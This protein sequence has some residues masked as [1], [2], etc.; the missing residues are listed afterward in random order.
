M[1][2]KLTSLLGI[3]TI[4]SLTAGSALAGNAALSDGLLAIQAKQMQNRATIVAQL[5]NSVEWG[6]GPVMA[7][8]L[9]QLQ[10]KQAANRREIAY[11]LERSYEM[12]V[13]PVLAVK[14]D[15]IKAKQHQNRVELAEKVG[16]RGG[17]LDAAPV[18]AEEDFGG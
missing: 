15:R 7:A 14:L 12:G 18:D 2:L 17:P 4:A 3:V 10:D 8:K 5:E 1:S 16:A 13:G 11:Q 6:V 9:M